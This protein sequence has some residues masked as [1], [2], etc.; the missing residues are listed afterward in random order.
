MRILTI[1]CWFLLMAY[2]SVPADATPTL[3]PLSAISAQQAVQLAQKKVPGRVL[4]VSKQVRSG[5]VIYHVKILT[6]D[7]RVRVVTIDGG[8]LRKS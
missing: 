7:G 4:S 1:A 8:K 3:L 2:V 5:R 6:K